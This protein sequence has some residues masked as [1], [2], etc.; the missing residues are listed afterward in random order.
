MSKKPKVTFST[1]GGWDVWSTALVFLILAFAGMAKSQDVPSSSLE[2]RLLDCVADERANWS[3]IGNAE[4]VG[5]SWQH[6]WYTIQQWDNAAGVWID[7][8]PIPRTII[9][10]GER[11]EVTLED[12][13]A[14]IYGEPLTADNRGIWADNLYSIATYSMANVSEPYYVAKR[15]DGAIYLLNVREDGTCKVGWNLGH[16][17]Q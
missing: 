12:G 8:Q 13:T 1:F 17:D 5:D 3:V 11:L 6:T 4:F 2:M 7:I 10:P 15:S 16:I 9:V 14:F